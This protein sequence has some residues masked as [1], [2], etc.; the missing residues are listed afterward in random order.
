[1]HS[2]HAL[3]GGPLDD[4]S[5][6]GALVSDGVGVGHRSDGGESA[7]SCGPGTRGD[8]LLVLATGLAQMHVQVDESGNDDLLGAFHDRRA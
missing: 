2:H 4:E 8:G 5:H 3:L 1:M 7:V 6:R